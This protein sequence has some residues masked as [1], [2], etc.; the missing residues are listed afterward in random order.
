MGA[1]LAIHAPVVGHSNHVMH[2]CH[3]AK[4]PSC[5]QQQKHPPHSVIL[6]VTDDL[7]YIKCPLHVVL[8]LTPVAYG[9]PANCTTV[10]C[11]VVGACSFFCR[12]LS[13]LGCKV[14]VFDLKVDAV[15]THRNRPFVSFSVVIIVLLMSPQS[16]IVGIAGMLGGAVVL[17]QVLGHHTHQV[18][19]VR[20][21]A[22][23]KVHS[24]AKLFK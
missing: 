20:Y 10:S 16:Q 21:S 12:L 6:C 24:N 7:P 1:V 22:T 23:N 19:Q 13:P 17:V 15:N 3:E 5:L 14:E 18:F 8:K 4:I 2:L 9:E 11:F